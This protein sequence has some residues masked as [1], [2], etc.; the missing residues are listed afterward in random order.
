MEDF[1]KKLAINH[2]VE[3][4]SDK[5][6]FPRNQLKNDYQ[7]ISKAYQILN[8]SIAKEVSIPPSGEW[9]LDNFYI[10]EETVKQ[11]KQELTKKKYRN[12]TF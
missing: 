9:L 11:I 8:E 4:H 10:I 1:A 12:L 6:T 5:K 3:R 7:V 2:Y